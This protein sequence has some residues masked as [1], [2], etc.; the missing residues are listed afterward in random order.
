MKTVWKFPITDMCAEIKAPGLCFPRFVAAQAGTM[1]VW[2]EVKPGEP[3]RSCV[4]TVHGTGHPIGDDE[5]YI[6][7]LMDGPFVWHAYATA[8]D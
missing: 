5:R 8:L 2:A 6:G 7:S 4:V 1:C 3:D